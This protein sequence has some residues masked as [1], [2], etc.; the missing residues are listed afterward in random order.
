MNRKKILVVD[1][2][3]IVLKALSMKLNANG[4]EVLT[5]D[6]GAGAVSVARKERPDLILLD[7][8]FPPDVAH[9]GG[10]AWDGFLIIDWLRRLEESKDVPIIVISGGDPAKYKQRALAKGAH[11]FFHKPIHHEE[12]LGSIQQILAEKT[13]KTGTQLADAGKDAF[14]I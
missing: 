11:S 2:S 4:Y 12:L 5:A 8:S 7:I 14:E 1:D 13:G 3:P 6:D 9:G 10:V